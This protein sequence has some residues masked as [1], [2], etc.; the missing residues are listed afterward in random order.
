MMSF[1][2]DS[3]W[4]FFLTWSQSLLC[5]FILHGHHEVWSNSALGL[6]S[7]YF[8]MKLLPYHA[9][10]LFITNLFHFISRLQSPSIPF[11]AFFGRPILICEV[12]Q[13]FLSQFKFNKF[14]H[15]IIFV[16][17]LVFINI[18]FQFV[19]GFF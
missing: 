10:F 2:T 17:F 6:R 3:S 12:F 7:H 19:L 13:P 8:F 15:H 14:F 4:T 9:F 1:K 5:L 18:S 16:S 11:Q